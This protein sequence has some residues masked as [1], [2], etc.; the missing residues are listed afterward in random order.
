MASHDSFIK[1]IKNQIHWTKYAKQYLFNQT[2][3]TKS[4]QP[5][6]PNQFYRRSKLSQIQ[7][8]AELGPAQPQLVSKLF[9]L[10]FDFGFNYNFNVLR[11]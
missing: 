2:Y 4:I 11:S 9:G 10:K 6:V 1:A 8:W 7:A 3:K 5:I